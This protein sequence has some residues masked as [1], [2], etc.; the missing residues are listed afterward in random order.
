VESPSTPATPSHTYARTQ[1]SM[2]L[3]A[4]ITTSFGTNFTA[5]ATSFLLSSSADADAAIADSRTTALSS[6]NNHR[7]HHQEGYI[8][9]VHNVE[10]TQRGTTKCSTHMAALLEPKYCIFRRKFEGGQS[11]EEGAVARVGEP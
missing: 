6:S 4:V 7:L 2:S 9:N 1:Q 5:L 8:Q 10:R 3:V 11:R